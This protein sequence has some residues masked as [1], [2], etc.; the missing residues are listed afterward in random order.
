MGAPELLP[1]DSPQWRQLRHSYGSAENVPALIRALGVGEESKTAEAAWDTL[2]GEVH[3][4]G[5]TYSATFA[6]L[7]HIVRIALEGHV[8]CSWQFFGWPASVEL[9]RLKN[10]IAVAPTELLSPYQWALSMI[11]QAVHRHAGRPWDHVF[12][13]AAC[14]ALVIAQSQ[15]LLA[16]VLLELGPSVAKD[17]IKWQFGD[18]A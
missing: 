7:P 15:V 11:P 9:Q 18:E 3:H 17:F 13:Q 2:W 16:E 10:D 8:P 6:T 12:A 4:Q 14:A 1:L 5:D